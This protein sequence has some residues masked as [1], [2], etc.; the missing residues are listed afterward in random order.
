MRYRT[1]FGSSAQSHRYIGEITEILEK[2]NPYVEKHKELKNVI[3]Q[4]QDEYVLYFTKWPD[5]RVYN[6]PVTSE[7]AAII[8]SKD[9]IIPDFDLCVH[10]KSSDKGVLLPKLLAHIDPMIFPTLFP[11]GDLGWTPYINADNRVYNKTN[12]SAAVLCLPSEKHRSVQSYLLWRQVT[13]AI[14]YSCIYSD[15]KLASQLFSMQSK[16]N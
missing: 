11:N 8:V 12:I 7:C 13:S 15:R 4:Y 14:H 2:Y 6:K 3:E 1:N 5:K 9:G 16:K 10:P